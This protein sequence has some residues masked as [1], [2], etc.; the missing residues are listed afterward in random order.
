VDAGQATEALAD[1]GADCFDDDGV[2]HGC[3][4]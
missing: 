4:P 2:A 1:G 3:S